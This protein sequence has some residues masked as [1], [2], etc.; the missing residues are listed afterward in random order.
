MPESDV[1]LSAVY[2][3]AAELVKKGWTQFCYARTSNGIKIN[4]L[5]DEATQWCITGSLL[6][7]ANDLGFP[8]DSLPRYVQYN[9]NW[10][11]DPERTQEEVANVLLELAGNFKDKE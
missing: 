11:D 5:D 8:F 3:R 2:Y 9:P 4:P 7:S 1:N 10:N 6:R